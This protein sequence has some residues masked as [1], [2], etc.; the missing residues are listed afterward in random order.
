M[1]E[2]IDLFGIKIAVPPG[3]VQAISSILSGMSNVGSLPDILRVDENGLIV[4][5]QPMENMTW[6]DIF[7]FQNLMV[8]QRLF[9]I[10]EFLR[11]QGEIK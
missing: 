7:Y 8:A 6:G 1:M 2:K 9:Q 11:K 4:G 3:D 5:F 10:D